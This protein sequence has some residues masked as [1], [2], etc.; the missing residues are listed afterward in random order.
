MS[1]LNVLRDD[2]AA[3]QADGL[4]ALADMIQNNPTLIGPA[5]D[6]LAIDF[7]MT[8][9]PPHPQQ[10]PK[11]GSEPGWDSAVFSSAANTSVIL[12]CEDP[13]EDAEDDVKQ[14][15]GFVKVRVLLLCSDHRRFR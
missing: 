12:P 10:L 2:G 1:P 7:V 4:R 8:R 6:D 9:A 11:K 3:Q 13:P 14:S 15:G 5:A